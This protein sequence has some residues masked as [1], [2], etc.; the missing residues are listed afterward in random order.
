MV[1]L[2][3]GKAMQGVKANSQLIEGLLL[4]WELGIAGK[5]VSIDRCFTLTELGAGMAHHGQL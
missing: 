4:D 1:E 5:V 3:Q 2:R